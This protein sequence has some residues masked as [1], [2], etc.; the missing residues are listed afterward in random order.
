MVALTLSSSAFP[1][2][3]PQRWPGL[4]AAASFLFSLSRSR[5]LWLVCLVLHGRL[6]LGL[7]VSLWRR[8]LRGGVPPTDCSGAGEGGPLLDS[9]RPRS[10]EKGFGGCALS[11]SWLG[12]RGATAAAT[13]GEGKEEGRVSE[14]KDR[15]VLQGHLSPS[16]GLL[17]STQSCLGAQHACSPRE[18]KIINKKHTLSHASLHK[19]RYS[20]SCAL[21]HCSKDTARSNLLKQMWHCLVS[22]SYSTYLHK[23]KK[24]A[25]E[26]SMS[27]SLLEI[28][29]LL[30]IVANPL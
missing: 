16:V 1:S 30:R 28:H 7:S 29:L 26:T 13:P 4:L 2:S 6:P 10:P 21:L 24:A 19:H 8:T 17:M 15:K 20:D 18:K 5:S 12:G 14:C 22:A 11:F 25:L 9:L 23:N 3:V 27:K